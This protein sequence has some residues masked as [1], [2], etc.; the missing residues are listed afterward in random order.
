MK[1]D[2]KQTTS[3]SAA[4]SPSS[5]AQVLTKTNVNPNADVGYEGLIQR[6][7]ELQSGVLP[8]LVDKNQ[9]FTSESGKQ[10]VSQ[11]TAYMKAVQHASSVE[12]EL[13]HELWDL[14]VDLNAGF[15]EMVQTS[16]G[17]RY[18]ALRELSLKNIESIQRLLRENA[19]AQ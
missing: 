1:A 13:R 3:Y 14:S 11:S 9:R 6:I 12:K 19:T 4:A 10:A 18:D 8:V 15:M 5:G 17:P 2:S 16:P 7:N